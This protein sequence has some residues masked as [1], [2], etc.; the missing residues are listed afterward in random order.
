[1]LVRRPIDRLRGSVCRFWTCFCGEAKTPGSIA[2]KVSLAFYCLNIQNEESEANN[3]TAK[4]THVDELLSSD[5]YLPEG[6]RYMYKPF[7]KCGI[8][9][10]ESDK[11]RYCG[12]RTTM[13]AGGITFEVRDTILKGRPVAIDP[14][15]PDASRSSQL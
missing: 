13:T 15:R 7:G 5:S 3:F 14:T 12:K 10:Q 2:S 4:T 6:N 9:T 11:F 1:M 8:R